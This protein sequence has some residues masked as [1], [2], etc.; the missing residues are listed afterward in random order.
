MPPAPPVHGKPDG[1]SLALELAV[2]Q[3][4]LANP[5]ASS[6]GW[7]GVRQSVMSIAAVDTLPASFLSSMEGKVFQRPPSARATSPTTS[8]AASPAAPEEPGF[9]V[10]LVPESPSTHRGAPV[11]FT[12]STVDLEGAADFHFAALPSASEPGVDE[13]PV[14]DGAP[15]S[16]PVFETSFSELGKAQVMVRAYAPDGRTARAFAQVEVTNRPPEVSVEGMPP[17]VHRGQPIAPL[18]KASDPD[19]DASKVSVLAPSG[20]SLAEGDRPEFALE[21]LGDNALTVRASD[22][23]GAAVEIPFSIAVTNR[24][25]SVEVTEKELR[26]HPGQGVSIEANPED[27]DGDITTVKAFLGDRELEQPSPG[28]F[29][30]AIHEPGRHEVR[31]EAT[32]E[33]GASAL[34]SAVVEVENR[35]PQ[36]TLLPEPPTGTRGS[37]IRLVEAVVDPDGDPLTVR[38]VVAGEEKTWNPGEMITASFA[39]LGPQEVEIVAEDSRGARVSEKLTVSVTNAPPVVELSLSPEVIHRGTEVKVKAIASDPEGEGLLY[40]FEGVGVSSSASTSP[41]ATL[42]PSEL[43]RV[44]VSVV[45]SDPHGDVAKAEKS[46]E[47]L[48]KPPEITLQT[49]AASTSRTDDVAVEVVVRCPETGEP[50]K[51]VR[52]LEPSS[53]KK[54]ESGFAGRFKAL[55]EHKIR[56]EAESNTGAKSEAEATVTVTNKPPSIAVLVPAA[57]HHRSRPARFDVK[58]EDAD[59]PPVPSSLE[60]RVDG[61]T[62]V[63]TDGSTAVVEY[64]RLGEISVTAVSTDPDGGTS[65]ATGKLSVEN[66]PPSIKVSAPP[67]PHHRTRPVALKVEVFDID[68]QGAAPLPEVTLDGQ[69]IQPTEGSYQVTPSRLGTHQFK[70]TASDSDGARA[71]EALS[72]EVENSPPAVELT[73]PGEAR[74]SVDEVTLSASG[75]DLEGG[76]IRYEFEAN[77]V[78]FPPTVSNEAKLTFT[79]P[80][81]HPVSVT[82]IDSDGARTTAKGEVRVE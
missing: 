61:G 28:V 58:Y 48:P 49:S 52:I 54:T 76:E 3:F 15:S 10:A 24:P 66:V 78:R 63:S 2:A 73:V 47:V 25:P 32:D 80:G 51:S 23:F 29:R 46:F 65:E 9:G 8:P 31:I 62:V 50:P 6:V 45:V 1:L 14:M 75:S 27:P 42:S 41:E 34:S 53:W 19:G 59:G 35:H 13:V 40:K 55:G 11:K 26:T 43:G 74:Q 82:A 70:V 71:E 17:S 57:P 68:G 64:S 67:S 60:W 56:V 36:I 18:L 77:G 44:S 81:K 37:P 38:T 79:K 39:S 22:S 4:F 20:E 30:L 21:T 72:I 69:V 33:H 12:A 16:S 7:D 5:D